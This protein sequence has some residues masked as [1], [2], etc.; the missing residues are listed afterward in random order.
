MLFIY[1]Y[2]GNSLALQR[3]PIGYHIQL[4]C[5]LKLLTSIART[6]LNSTNFSI[7]FHVFNLLGNNLYSDRICRQIKF[8][9]NSQV[10]LKG[11]PWRRLT[12]IQ[13][14]EASQTLRNHKSS[15]N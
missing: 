10:H 5:L 8:S 15:T 14:T 1:L 11:V 12:E 4:W 9:F 13:A 2:S 7:A 6:R 3:V